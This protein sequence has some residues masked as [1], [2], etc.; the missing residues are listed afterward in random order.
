MLEG[1]EQRPVFLEGA[2]VHQ[3]VDILARH[4]VAH[5]VT[6]GDGLRAV[7]V[8]RMGVAADNLFKV[9]TDEVR[10]D[11]PAAL[12]EI[13]LDLR[14]LDE[15]DGPAFAHHV[16]LVHRHPAHDP[17][18][19]GPDFVLHLHRLDHRNR[20]ARENPV[21]LRDQQRDDGALDGRRH[22]GE[23]LGLRD[24]PAVLFGPGRLDGAVMIEERERVRAVHAGT[25]EA[26]PAVRLRRAGGETGP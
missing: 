26:V 14:R 20:L 13:A 18:L 22:A 17:G 15:G 9:R 16:A 19:P 24:L 21:P 11:F 5:P 8:Q 12:G 6:P 23:A 1:G 2:G 3:P 4:P 7:L 25:G 10:I